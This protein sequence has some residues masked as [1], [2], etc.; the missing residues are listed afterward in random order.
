MTMLWLV[1]LKLAIGEGAFTPR[2]MLLST[3]TDIPAVSAK[4]FWPGP[5][6]GAIV[7]GSALDS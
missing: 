4:C 1:L 2:S 6:G 7:A 3:S 5:S